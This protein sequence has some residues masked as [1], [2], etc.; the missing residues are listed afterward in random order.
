MI[1]LMLV[2]AAQAQ[3]VPSWGGLRDTAG[4][5]PAGEW[6][7]RLPTGRSAVGLTDRTEVWVQ[8]VGMAFAGS[9]LGLEQLVVDQ[10]AWAW[11]LAPAAGS[12]WTGREAAAELRSYL[13]YSA[14]DHRLNLTVAGRG[15]LV[16]QAQLS[17]TRSHAWSADRLLVPVAL[18]HDLSRGQSIWRTRL[19]VAAIDEG[20]PLS[21]GTLSAS[22]IHAFGR[23]HVEL[24]AGVLVG[25]PSEHVFLGTY[26]HTLA[27]MYPTADLWWS[28]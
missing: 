17:D 13:S 1:S 19:M 22:W 21:Y 20:V 15:R 11:S 23:L 8:P 16:R 12:A 6:A 2:L 10:G 7:V 27:V 14:G 18:A 24:G 28:F 25:K 4:T 3:D 9:R 26:E 5:L